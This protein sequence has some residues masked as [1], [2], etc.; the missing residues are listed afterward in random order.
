M[1]F[2]RKDVSEC[3][4][5]STGEDGVSTSICQKFGKGNGLSLLSQAVSAVKGPG[6]AVDDIFQATFG[7]DVGIFR[8][9]AHDGFP[10]RA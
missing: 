7:T 4:I 1:I 8:D 3:L 2:F 6:S 10:V 5:I 9:V